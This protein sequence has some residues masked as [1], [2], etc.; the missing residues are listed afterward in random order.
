MLQLHAAE[1][2][3]SNLLYSCYLGGLAGLKEYKTQAKTVEGLCQTGTV[4]KHNENTQ[5]IDYMQ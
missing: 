1:V 2:Y 5:L 4:Y 3:P